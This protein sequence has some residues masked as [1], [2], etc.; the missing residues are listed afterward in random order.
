MG[1][2][3]HA[4]HL[5]FLYRHYDVM[6]CTAENYLFLDA[7]NSQLANG[8]ETYNYYLSPTSIYFSHVGCTLKL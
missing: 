2:G 5:S 7:Y 3:Q 4:H 8:V 6:W 1:M